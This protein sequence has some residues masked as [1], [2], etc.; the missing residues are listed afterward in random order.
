M[1]SGVEEPR[2]SPTPRARPKTKPK[3]TIAR[4]EKKAAKAQAA[5]A[6]AKRKKDAKRKRTTDIEAKWLTAETWVGLILNKILSSL[7]HFTALSRQ[8]FILF[9]LGSTRAAVGSP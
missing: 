3:A 4:A 5:E 6:K 9:E 7:V 8:V 2:P 1:L